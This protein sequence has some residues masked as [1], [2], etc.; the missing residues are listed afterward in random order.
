MD[1]AA[2]I[3]AIAPDHR[4]KV[5]D[6]EAQARAGLQRVAEEA[7]SARRREAA[8]QERQA[9]LAR[10]YDRLLE[11]E[12]AE[13]LEEVVKLARQI[14]AQQPGYRDVPTRLAQAQ[15]RLKRRPSQQVCP[16][17]GR[18]IAKDSRFCEDCG[19]I[20]V[21]TCPKC[22]ADCP[23]DMRFCSGCGIDLEAGL[24]AE[25][26]EKWIKDALLT[27]LGTLYS[28]IV[29]LPKEQ[30][31]AFRARIRAV[32]HKHRI[33]KPWYYRDL[34]V[35]LMIFSPC[36]FVGGL[37]LWGDKERSDG[38][39]HLGLIL[40]WGPLAL[41]FASF[42]IYVVLAILGIGLFGLR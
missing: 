41:M 30:R 37:L 12:A 31:P 15:D 40:F 26:E 42:I 9:R 17:C 20:L 24:T 25:R 18:S 4:E 28:R 2:E 16:Q 19:K 33:K 10:L 5:T 22:G 14:E 35:G 7:E 39:R 36:W 23:A 11:R 32:R 8:E 6:V 27:D 21:V 29:A 3:V 13:D 1:L 34:F 38:T